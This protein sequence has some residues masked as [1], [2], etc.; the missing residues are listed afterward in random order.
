MGCYAGHVDCSFC[1]YPNDEDARFCVRCAAAL[2]V[3]IES[4]PSA[5]PQSPFAAGNTSA[6]VISQLQAAE[7]LAAH[8][9]VGSQAG[10]QGMPV[11]DGRYRLLRC[12]GSGG[13]GAVY[14]AEELDSTLR[15]A[16]KLLHRSALHEPKMIER[17]LQEARMIALLR[18]PHVVRLFHYGVIGQAGLDGPEGAEGGVPYLAMELLT[19]RNLASLMMRSVVS[20]R[21]AVLIAAQ[22]CDALGEAH[23]Q[24][25]VHRDIK[26]DNVL[27]LDHLRARGSGADFVKVIDFGVARFCGATTRPSDILGTPAYISPE[28]LA[29]EPVDG[30]SDLYSVGILLWQSVLGELPF[31]STNQAIMMRSHLT[32]PRR[33]PSELFPKLRG[34]LPPALEQLMVRLIARQPADRPHSAYD[35]RNELLALVDR[36]SDELLPEVPLPNFGPCWDA[37]LESLSKIEGARAADCEPAAPGQQGASSAEQ[38]ITQKQAPDDALLATMRRSARVQT[39]RGLGQRLRERV[40]RLF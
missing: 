40:Q 29:N 25:I 34:R 2:G 26:P 21:R 14:E 12:L 19:G 5:A 6:H 13:F 23:A 22:V 11:L 3:S 37:P 36:L 33:L 24:G 31:P 35:V 39:R 20:P 4:L 18:S 28:T 1:A 17:F 32:A 8:G 27:L 30:R 15:V 10:A 7:S 38:A 9:Q 16:V